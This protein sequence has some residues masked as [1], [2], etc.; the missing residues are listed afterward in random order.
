[1]ELRV[2]AETRPAN[3]LAA[4]EHL[5]R[6]AN[7]INPLLERLRRIQRRWRRGH[8]GDVLARYGSRPAAPSPATPPTVTPIS[9]A[10]VTFVI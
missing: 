8:T 10:R 9:K 2:L 7:L 6:E 3:A 4:I 1:L 5:A